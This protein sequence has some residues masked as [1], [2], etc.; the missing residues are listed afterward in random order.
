MKIFVVHGTDNKKSYERLSKFITTA[1]KR[2]W[3]IVNDKIEDTPSLFNN[4]KLI[5]IRDYKILTKADLHLAEKIDGYLV[6]YHKD[7]LPKTFL[8]SIKIEKEEK[9]DLPII[10]WKFLDSFDLTLFHQLLED[11]AV[12]YV[13]AMIA[14][15]LKQKYI[16]NP[17]LENG[18]LISE[19][20]EIDVK[21][22][23]G[24]VDLKLALEIFLLKHF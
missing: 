8:N 5:I 12:E 17:T 4:E 20:T 14:W 10:L 11:N 15:K 23:T 13:F 24:K 18:K 2:D 3:E 1:K 6:I 16:N 9:Y 22:K 7:N 19:L 21:S